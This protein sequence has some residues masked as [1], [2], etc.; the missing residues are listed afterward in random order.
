MI[1]P[2]YCARMLRL[3][4]VTTSS[5]LRSKK[6]LEESTMSQPNLTIGALA[7]H[8]STN[9]P[10]I[11]YYEEIGLLPQAQRSPNGRRFYRDTDLKRLTFIKRCRDFG[12]PIEQVREL[13]NLLEDGDRSCIEVRDLAQMRLDTVRARLLEMRQLEASLVSFVESCDEACC[14]G[15]TRDCN[16]I[17]DWST[18]QSDKSIT[19]DGSCC[20][21]LPREL[22]KLTPVASTT[23]KQVRRT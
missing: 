18:V 4:Q 8:T 21:P 5:N 13:V 15:P 9:V 20:A 10:T 17:E 19:G 23:F 2:F 12:F 7:T 22:K 1:S 3:H 11:R 16:I 14:K 6:F